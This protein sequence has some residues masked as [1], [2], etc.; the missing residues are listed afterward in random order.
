V[1]VSK[2]SESTELPKPFLAKLLQNLSK[3]GFVRSYKGI[4]GG[5]ILAKKPEE[6]NIVEVF[7][8]LKDKDSIVF[9]CS[10]DGNNCT[11][12]KRYKICELWPFFVKMEK[13]IS[14]I[15]KNYTLADVIRMSAGK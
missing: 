5:F 6:I 7:K 9:Y 13:E 11:R 2:I 3:N 1:D 8:S 10:S 12:E 15:L 14:N 4:N